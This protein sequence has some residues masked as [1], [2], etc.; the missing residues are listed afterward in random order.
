M[1]A[2]LMMTGVLLLV[3]VGCQKKTFVNEPFDAGEACQANERVVNG[4]CRFVCERDG[5]CAAGERCNLFT[6]S[7]ETKPPV[8]DAG[9]VTTLCTTG[10]ERCTVDGKGMLVH[11]GARA[12]TL[13][14]GVPAPVDVMRAALS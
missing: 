2:R 10:A 3:A 12:F 1:R 4:S 14:L 9:N 13:W 11:Q 6:G 5:E 7:C 8:P